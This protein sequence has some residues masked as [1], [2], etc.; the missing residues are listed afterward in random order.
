MP[1]QV[2]ASEINRLV[3]GLVTE[4]SPLTFP[5]NASIDE[6]NFVLSRDGTRSRRLGMDYDAD[7]STQTVASSST[8]K[9]DVGTSVFVWSNADNLIKKNLLV[10]QVGSNIS[11]YDM[12]VTPLSSGLIDKVR[13][14]GLDPSIRVS[15]ASVD[16]AV[17]MTFGDPFL[18]LFTFSDTI[19]TASPLGVISFSSGAS[20][21]FIRDTFGAIEENALEIDGRPTIPSSNHIY[22]LRNQGWGLPKLYNRDPDKK[23]KI[24]DP[25]EV[26]GDARVL[27]AENQYPSNFDNIA[28]AIFPDPG[29]DRDSILDKFQPSALLESNPGGSRSPKGHFIIPLL[30]RGFGRESGLTDMHIKY[31]E[32]LRHAQTGVL[33]EDK[34]I[35]GPTCVAEFAGRAWFGG[36]GGDV[37]DP[38]L[39]A[40]NLVSYVAFSQ[41]I[42]TPTNIF[43]CYQEGDPT[44]PEGADLLATD[45]GLIK[46]SGAYGIKAMVNINVALIIVAENGLWSVTGGGDFGFDATNPV[47]SKL[48]SHGCISA[49]SIVEVDSTLFYWADD[50]I[51]H[52]TPSD[53]TG[54]KVENISQAV[55]Q[56]YYS[57]ID[58]LD[59]SFSEGSYD[60]VTNTVRW[61]YGGRDSS[62]GVNRELM[63]DLTLGAFYPSEFST[64]STGFPRVVGMFSTKPYITGATVETIVVSGDTVVVFGDPIVVSTPAI[65]NRASGIKYLIAT[66]EGV[67][68]SG[69]GEISSTVAF[70]SYTDTKFRDWSTEY[71]TD[72]EDAEAFIVTGYVPSGDFQRNKQ[73]PWIT[74]HFLK[75]ETGFELD[76]AGEIVATNEGGCLVQAQWD[77]S[78]TAES[79]RWGA[80]FQA[81]RHKRLFIP[82]N[83]GDNF[84]DGSLVVSTKNKIRGKGKVLSLLIKSQPDKDLK[85][86]GMSSILAVNGNV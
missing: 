32:L 64:D 6:V 36:F 77:W 2:L 65:F 52:V 83:V 56:T 57:N 33:S 23:G 1:R 15:F 80:E 17:I 78:N 66:S 84:N 50:G 71:G 68:D 69:T 9:I 12:D 46:V 48:T 51:Y 45:G 26:F 11:F 8:G 59:A 62:S 4:A 58:Y 47:V 75:T 22:N 72:G 35:G 79:N 18:T 41:L 82:P 25:I 73:A 7:S 42:T 60:V 70:G 85:F 49:G 10:V 76:E 44:T 55:I 5:E 31:P 20:Q 81:Y 43:K 30:A 19:S 13:L 27:G 53:I 38:D 28:G 37:E 24:S 67:F 34:T 61:V 3:K 16:D 14:N 21:L 86:L 39:G 40:P 74:F 54:F 29:D 63:L